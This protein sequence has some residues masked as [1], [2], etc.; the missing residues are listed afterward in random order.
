MP[1]AI[2]RLT[3]RVR[4]ECP[5]AVSDGQGGQAVTWALRAVVAALVEP[6]TGREALMAQQWSAELSTAVTIWFRSDISVKDRVR[7]GPRTLEIQNYLDPDGRRAEL[8]L[9]CSE[10]QA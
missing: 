4:I 7:V 6:L 8:R 1:T 9:L 5:V 10:V 2:G 3:Q